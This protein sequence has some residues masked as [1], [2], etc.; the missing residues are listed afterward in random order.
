[1][2]Q[3]GTKH[4][5]LPTSGT[6]PGA[7]KCAVNKQIYPSPQESDDEARDYRPSPKALKDHRDWSHR[8]TAAVPAQLDARQ[9]RLHNSSPEEGRE[10]LRL[11]RRNRLYSRAWA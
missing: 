8:N 3:V 6:A 1:M 9:G 10:I 5:W 4:G 2:F 7:F 11:G